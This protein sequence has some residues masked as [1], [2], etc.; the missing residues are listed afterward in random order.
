MDI[1]MIGIDHENASIQEREAFAF[2][3]AQA[4]RALQM[5]AREESYCGVLLLSTCNRTELW[6]SADSAREDPFLQLCRAKGLDP[7]EYEHLLARRCGDE[8]VMHLLQLICGLK[9]RIYGEDQILSQIRD[10]LELSRAHGC[11]DIVIE[12]LFQTAISAGKRVRTQ[13]KLQNADPSAAR[14]ALV[15]LKQQLGGLRD[16]PCLIIGNGQMGKMTANLLTEAGAKVTMTLRKKL[17]VQEPRDSIIPE[18][19][20]MIDYDDRVREAERYRAVISATLSP[21]FTVSKEQ[22]RGKRFQNSIWIDMAVP[23]DIEPAVGEIPGIQL[24][25]MD[26]LGDSHIEERTEQSLREA[27]EIL[28]EYQQDLERWFAFR[29]H[30]NTVK[31]I[32]GM[33][34]EDA[35]KR[36]EKPLH[37][38]E[39]QGAFETDLCESIE[40]AVEKSVE[41][42]LFGLRDTLPPHQ[43]QSCLDALKRSAQRDTLKTG[44]GR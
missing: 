4:G 40:T 28:E 8:A 16:V 11:N 25:D 3:K 30:I 39:R 12:K 20:R 19:C 26:Q 17:H 24:Y 35:C 13:V 7:G 5:W 23:R 31:E 22:L 36:M 43:W 15:L 29:K 33:A 42:M 41:K 14:S 34:G 32:S 38:A 44:K 18:G 10:A 37:Q 21:H 27:M 6:V 1:I 2:T 9:S